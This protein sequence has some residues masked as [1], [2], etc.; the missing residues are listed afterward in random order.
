IPKLNFNRNHDKLFFYAAYEYMNQLP[1]GSVNER[2][3]PTAQM[4]GGNFSPSYL[5]SLGPQLAAGPFANNTFAPCATA[6]TNG[7]TFPGGI[8]P[9]SLLDPN[10]AALFKTFPQPNISTTSN[11]QGANYQQ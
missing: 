4:M 7:V 1:S 11:P 8:I 3:I 2:F 9:A 5:A 6:C 10:S